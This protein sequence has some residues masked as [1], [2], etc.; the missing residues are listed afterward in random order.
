MDMEED[1]DMDK[2]G[3]KIGS[4]DSMDM[5]EE[6]LVGGNQP[7]DSKFWKEDQEE[8]QS[9]WMGRKKAEEE[10]RL[11]Q[12]WPLQSMD[13]LLL[14]H[15][16]PQESL[17]S[18]R[19]VQRVLDWNQLHTWMIVK[20]PPRFTESLTINW[21]PAFKST[22]SSDAIAERD[23][24]ETVNSTP[25]KEHKLHEVP[26]WECRQFCMWCWKS[27]SLP[28]C[29]RNR[30]YS[31]YSHLSWMTSFPTICDKEFVRDAFVKLFT[32]T[33][34]S[35]P[36]DKKLR[37]F[38][39]CHDRPLCQKTHA[40]VRCPQGRAASSQMW[41]EMIS[42]DWKKEISTHLHVRKERFEDITIPFTKKSIQ[43]L[44]HWIFPFLIASSLWMKEF[45]SFCFEVPGCTN[46]QQQ[47]LPRECVLEE[48]AGKMDSRR[49]SSLRL[50]L[51][52]EC[53]H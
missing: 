17:Q 16:T 44:I 1:K 32:F 8:R 39:W 11:L 5:E 53:A 4:L 25:I 29:R 37:D 13:P 21:V 26:R 51:L 24:K 6:P 34:I 45:P 18:G 42:R 23:W 2:V 52:P 9:E 35:S 10:K 14:H 7:R 15:H 50:Q 28:R 27:S 20:S 36:L 30:D 49:H 33:W 19:I 47:E 38:F 43:M 31:K 22:S 41:E 48:T 12:I 40:A 46:E 3:W